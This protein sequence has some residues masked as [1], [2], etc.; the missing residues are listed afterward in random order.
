[1]ALSRFPVLLSLAVGGAL[2]AGGKSVNG[3]VRVY[4]ALTRKGKR[5]LEHLSDEWKRV[6]TGVNYKAINMFGANHAAEAG[7]TLDEMALIVHSRRKAGAYAEE[8]SEVIRL[9]RSLFRR[10]LEEYPE[11]AAAL[12]DRIAAE[13]TDKVFVIFQRLHGRDAYSGTGIGLALC[14]KIVEVR[15]GRIWVESEPGQ[16]SRF[17]F[18][19]PAANAPDAT[20]EGAQPPRQPAVNTTR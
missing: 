2:K 8:D 10:I 3:R 12:R 20:G 11:V 14:K 17:C 1:M 13:F 18:T 16:G 15:G 6:S 19:L 4:Y 5:R 7:G 9:N